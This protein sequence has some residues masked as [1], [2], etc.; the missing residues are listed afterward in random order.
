MTSGFT[1]PDTASENGV[2]G[3][4][5]CYVS[6]PDNNKIMHLEGFG[7]INDIAFDGSQARSFLIVTQKSSNRKIAYPLT[8]TNGV[9]NLSHEGALCQNASAC[10]FEVYIDVSPYPADI[11]SLGLVIAYKTVGTDNVHYAYYPFSGDISFTVLDGQV[12]TPVNTVD[13][14]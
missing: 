9:S 2:I 4:T 5:A 7:Y 8:L 11:Y 12:V 6:Q 3:I 1:V 14:E 10:D 13:Y